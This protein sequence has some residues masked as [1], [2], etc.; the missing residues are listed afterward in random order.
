MSQLRS[1][2]HGGSAVFKVPETIPCPVV[3]E[4]AEQRGSGRFVRLHGGHSGVPLAL[5]PDSFIKALAEYTGR[6]I[7]NI[8]L[9]RIK[10]NKH[11]MKIFFNKNRAVEGEY[12]ND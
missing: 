10:T 11:L 5:V 4:T 1:T 3:F 8:N 12:M 7:I 2:S 6:S 9:A